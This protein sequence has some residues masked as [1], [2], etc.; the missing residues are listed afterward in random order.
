MDRRL[1]TLTAITGSRS[2]PFSRTETRKASPML[3]GDEGCTIIAVGQSAHPVKA[4]AEAK[5]AGAAHASGLGLGH[6]LA[7]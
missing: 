1:I 3:S 2:R 6:F 4:A 5:P 7:S